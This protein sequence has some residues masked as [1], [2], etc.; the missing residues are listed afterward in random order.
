MQA[1]IFQDLAVPLLECFFAGYNATILAY[2]QTVSLSS[3]AVLQATG[4][5]K[6]SRP[7]SLQY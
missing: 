6:T 2:G 5:L 3:F 1:V 7:P 4:Y